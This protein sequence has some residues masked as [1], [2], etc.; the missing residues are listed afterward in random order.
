[1]ELNLSYNSLAEYLKLN[2]SQQNI[3]LSELLNPLVTR[4]KLYS[5]PLFRQDM[6]AN[7]KLVR[8]GKGMLR[9]TKQMATILAT[10]T[11]ASP[12]DQDGSWTAPQRFSFQE[13]SSGPSDPNTSNGRSDLNHQSSQNSQS[14][15][16][17]QSEEE[18][19][20][21]PPVRHSSA[22]REEPRQPILLSRA[23]SQDG[24]TEERRKSGSFLARLFKPKKAKDAMKARESKG[25]GRLPRRNSARSTPSTEASEPISLSFNRAQA[26]TPKPVRRSHKLYRSYSDDFQASENRLAVDGCAH[27]PLSNVLSEV[28]PAPE[29]EAAK[30]LW[31]N[32]NVPA[33]AHWVGEPRGEGGS[34]EARSEGES[35]EAWGAPEHHGYVSPPPPRSEEREDEATGEFVS[36]EQEEGAPPSFDFD[37]FMEKSGPSSAASGADDWSRDLVG[38]GGMRA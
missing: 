17:S 30:R 6:M 16:S 29:G 18:I 27:D 20:I 38:E 11:P 31:L 1:M 19:Q 14:S 36:L 34:D 25:D 22:G 3:S 32:V 10:P 2:V 8:W 21:A 37:A 28:A 15:Q 23:R 35:D 4:A 26:H 9:K 24:L 13:A 5:N 33:P 7:D 12:R